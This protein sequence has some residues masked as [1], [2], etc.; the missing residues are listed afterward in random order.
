MQIKGYGVTVAW[1]GQTLRAK[2]TNKLAHFA[3]LG[4]NEVDINDHIQED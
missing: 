3:L 2:G 1:D 4:Q